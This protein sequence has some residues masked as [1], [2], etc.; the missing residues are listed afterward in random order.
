MGDKIIAALGTFDHR[1]DFIPQFFTELTASGKRHKDWSSVELPHYTVIFLAKGEYR[2]HE[3]SVATS[4]SYKE[5]KKAR[6]PYDEE[7]C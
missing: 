2:L 5:Y 6:K 1:G 7:L 3:F 4:G